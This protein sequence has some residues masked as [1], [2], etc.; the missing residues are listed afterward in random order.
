M[1]FS[2]SHYFKLGSSILFKY[3]STYDIFAMVT[4]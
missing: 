3:T 1:I 2:L 4:S